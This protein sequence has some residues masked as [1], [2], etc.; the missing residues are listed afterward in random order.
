MVREAVRSLIA[1]GLLAD[2]PRRGHVVCAL[3]RDTVTESLTLYLRGQRLDY[4]N[5]WRRAPWSR[6][7]TPPEI[8]RAHARRCACTS[9]K[10]SEG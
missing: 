6:S 2:N 4:G 10:P 3:G 9:P 5:S 1:K 7:R 8:V